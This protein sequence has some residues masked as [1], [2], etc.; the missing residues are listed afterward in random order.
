MGKSNR[1][2]MSTANCKMCAHRETENSGHSMVKEA[3]IANP[4]G[5]IMARDAMRTQEPRDAQMLINTSIVK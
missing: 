4:H 1:N 5:H 3:G 2:V